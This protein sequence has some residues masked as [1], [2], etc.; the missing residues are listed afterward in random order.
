[1]PL[2]TDQVTLYDS[3]QIYVN[4]PANTTISGALVYTFTQSQEYSSGVIRMTVID[5]E[6]GIK[7]GF[8]DVEL[9]TL[10]F[11]DNGTMIFTVRIPKINAGQNKIQIWSQTGD[12]Q[13]LTR[14]V[15]KAGVQQN[16]ARK[17]NVNKI[18]DKLNQLYTY[19]SKTREGTAG[20]PILP[21]RISTK[22]KITKASINSIKNVINTLYGTTYTCHYYNENKVTDEM[23]NEYWHRIQNYIPIALCY[24]CDSYHQCDCDGSGQ[25][26]SYS[27]TC[28]NRCDGFTS[29]DCNNQCNSQSCRCYN[30]QYRTCDCNNQ[31]YTQI[32]ECNYE[33]YYKCDCNNTC[34][35]E[36]K[37]TSGYY[38]CT[39]DGS[40]VF[41]SC[42]CYVSCDVA[43]C[44]CDW[45]CD[46]YISCDC[47]Y[48]TY[49]QLSCSIDSC[50]CNNECYGYIQ[51]TCN[52]T[53]DEVT[54]SAYYTPCPGY[55]CDPYS[56]NI[57][58]C[59]GSTYRISCSCYNSYYYDNTCDCYWT[60]YASCLCN[61]S[62]NKDSCTCQSGCDSFSCS[63]NSKCDGYIGCNCNYTCYGFNCSCESKYN[64]D[65]WACYQAANTCVPF[66][67]NYTCTC[68][69]QCDTYTYDPTKTSCDQFSLC[70]SFSDCKS[71]KDVCTSYSVSTCGE[72]IAQSSSQCSNN[73]GSPQNYSPIQGQ[74][75][76]SCSCYS[77]AVTNCKCN[78]STYC[79]TDT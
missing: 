50:T 47:D 5:A 52:Y 77:S 68:D 53:C 78:S 11:D 23:F 4:I 1:M 54:C 7:V 32:C 27:C 74:Y 71:Y 25:C 20:L 56:D 28:N 12:G 24:S 73:R 33:T 66:S 9:R 45:G 55:Y 62:C 64:F 70:T 57:C 17:D 38:S 30:M 10:L 26:H 48:T 43:S 31:F 37:C 3:G 29:C 79:S 42:P 65:C 46:G 21:Q 59:N 60:T 35:N 40:Y 69:E 39:C 67:S 41:T 18:I 16:V 61:N 49:K 44:D 8:N 14:V 13:I 76:Y 34:Y 75:L 58:D 36:S 2:N 63:C 72:D 19:Y 22:Q 15:V 6:G 51:C